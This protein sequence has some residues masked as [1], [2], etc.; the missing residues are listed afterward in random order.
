M[1]KVGDDYFLWDSKVLGVG[2]QGATYEG[3]NQKT[4]QRVAIKV[5]RVHEGSNSEIDTLKRMYESTSSTSSGVTNRT[6]KYVMKYYT[7]F[8]DET[9]K[10]EKG[11]IVT[12]FIDGDK[13]FSMI[14]DEDIEDPIFVWTIIYQLLLGLKFIH[15]KGVVHGDI[16]Q[17]NIMI[18]TDNIVKYIDFGL[19]CISKC[20]EDNK[21]CKSL[22]IKTSLKPLTEAEEQQQKKLDEQM[23]I[24]TTGVIRRPKSARVP[25]ETIKLNSVDSTL[26]I[27]SLD[28][29]MLYDLLLL[30]LASNEEDEEKEK[31]KYDDGRT[32]S[33]MDRIF[34]VVL[35]GKDGE[36]KPFGADINEM[37]QIFREEV[38]SKPWQDKQLDIEQ[39]YSEESNY[40]TRSGAID[41]ITTLIQNDP[42]VSKKL[43]SIG[44]REVNKKLLED[45]I[46][47]SILCDKILFISSNV[48]YVLG[49]L[50][51]L[52]QSLLEGKKENFKGFP[53]REIFL[54]F[55]S[56]FERIV[57][58]LASAFGDQV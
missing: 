34:N 3:S 19:S 43:P 55:Y 39:K 17:D 1:P 42:L 32:N 41:Y 49:F 57:E 48:Y 14:S 40:F 28:R 8:L 44:S 52:K 35:R 50:A 6:S 21:D 5:V 11:S 16:N 30:L 33:F 23:G 15:S 2:G 38:L 26:S 18:T 37:L 53:H 36:T 27:Q 10:V 22:C 7:S 47:L 58:K 54:E 51:V 46:R 29:R 25:R 4:G 9:G 56:L 13:I 24:K 45:M 12:E 20:P 31:Y